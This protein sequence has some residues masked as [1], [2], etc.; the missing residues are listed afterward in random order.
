MHRRFVAPQA[1]WADIVIGPD[2][3]ARDVKR[4]AV[5]IKKANRPGK[6]S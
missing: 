4:L 1:R 5:A 2:W 6:A 3:H